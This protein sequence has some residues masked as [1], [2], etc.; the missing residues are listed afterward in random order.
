MPIAIVR[1][2]ATPNPNALKCTVDRRL[3]EGS[4][5]YRTADGA[6]DDPVA[7]ALFRVAG[8]TGVLIHEDW[9]TVSKQPDAAWGP[10]RRGVESALAG[11][12]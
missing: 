10:I 7:G 3:C 9:I 2:E 5:S 11:V 12:P 6:A 8:V 4:R 1:F